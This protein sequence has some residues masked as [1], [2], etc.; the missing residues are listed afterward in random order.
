MDRLPANRDL[1]TAAT[2]TRMSRSFAVRPYRATDATHVA[3]LYASVANPYR[4]EDADHELSMQRR[5][6]RAQATGERWSPLIA[7]ESNVEEEAH[8]AFWV[9][10]TMNRRPNELIGT[11][12]LR[13]VG[14]EQ[15]VRS[16]TAEWSGLPAIGDWIASGTVGEIRRLRVAHEWRRRGVA[17]ALTRALIASSVESHRLRGLILNTTSAQIPALAFY[18]RFGFQELGRSYLGTYELVW[19]YLTLS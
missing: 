5:A 13:R 8:L 3:R 19:M 11:L 12:G 2:A 10:T 6:R 1:S 15:T 16:D 4:P 9:A 14:D 17:T 7:E 18:G